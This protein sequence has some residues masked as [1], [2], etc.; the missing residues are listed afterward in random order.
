MRATARPGIFP[1]YAPARTLR[2]L[3]RRS[4]TFAGHWEEERALL[5]ADPWEYGLSAI[6]KKNYDT[7]VGFVHEQVLS[8]RRPAL[9][10]LFPEEAFA[11]ELP[12]PRMHQIDYRF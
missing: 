3:A 10:D 6:N 5:G 7:L 8:G 11:L 4:F 12:L 2:P 1:H 9:E